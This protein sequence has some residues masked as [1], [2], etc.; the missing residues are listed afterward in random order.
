MVFGEVGSHR[1]GQSMATEKKT[2]VRVPTAAH[3]EKRLEIIAHCANLFEKV[4]Y[5]G[6]TMQMLA[7]EAALGKPTLYHY[8]SSKEDIL[9]EMHQLHI[10]AMIAALDA[11]PEKCSDPGEV[12]TRA[13]AATLR[14]IAEH[15]GYV[16]AF[17]EH[18]G[19]LEGDHREQMRDRR[20]HYF[21]RICAVVK[22]GISSGKFRVSDPTITTLAFLG[23]CN[24]SYKWYAP[25]ADE[26]PPERM[27]K[28][29]CKVFLEGLNS[30]IS[31]K[32]GML[33]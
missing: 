32:D 9:F 6:L 14:E 27:A 29:L 15:P 10:D 16:R 31:T 19:D 30:P 18:Y 25:K 12:L 22:S 4:G 17:M 3:D 8:F 28:L 26:I 24:W 5:Y 33:T 23:M 13:C 2:K 11:V 1:R 7:D 20:Q 21:D